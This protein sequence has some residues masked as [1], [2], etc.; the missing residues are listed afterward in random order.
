MIF[1]KGAK[2]E[3]VQF[4]HFTKNMRRPIGRVVDRLVPHTYNDIKCHIHG[5]AESPVWG[6]ETEA[7]HLY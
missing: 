5:S 2:V 6:V 3:T 1:I 7:R 4:R